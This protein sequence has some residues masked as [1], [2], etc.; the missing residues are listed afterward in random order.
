MS[1]L[2]TTVRKKVILIDLNQTMLSNLMSQL[3]NHTNAQV[4]E[5]MF[6]HMVLNAIRSYKQKFGSEYGEMIIACDN[7]NYWRKKIFPYYKANR[8]KA[9]A[10]SEMNW[11]DIFECMNKIRAELKEFFPYRVIDVDS[12]EADDIIGTLV[13]EFGLNINTGEKILI[14]SGDKDFIQLHTYANVKQFDPV[15]KK[16]IT[17]DQPETYLKEHIMKGDASDGIPNILS[18][19]N[20]F[21]VGERQ[22]PLTKKK[23]DIYLKMNPLNFGNTVI[24]RNYSRNAQLIDLNNIP[25]E[26]KEKVMEQYK[27]QEGRDRSKLINYFMVH[28]LK[29]LTEYISEF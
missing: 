25:K 14:L 3:G 10:A 11:K 23:I 22:R 5:N 17:N 19:D 29:N 6:R 8:K 7:T 15:R 24:E 2:K 13:F 4:E 20:C 26:I 12:A 28:K 9:I 18:S 16:W 1:V 21:V 27:N